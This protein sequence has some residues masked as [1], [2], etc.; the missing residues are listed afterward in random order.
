[1]VSIENFSVK[2][3]MQAAQADA[4]S[5][6]AGVPEVVTRSTIKDFVKSPLLAL[7]EAKSEKWIKN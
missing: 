7:S 5:A 6:S 4:N 2:K 3:N 1:M